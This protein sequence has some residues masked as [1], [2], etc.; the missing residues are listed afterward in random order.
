M[1]EQSNNN[2]KAADIL[3]Q[4]ANSGVPCA[5]VR[6]LIAD[7]SID[8]AYAI[9]QINI[10]RNLAAGGRLVGSKIGLTAK[11]VQK[12]LGVDQPDFGCLLADMAVADGEEIEWSRVIQPKVEAEVALVLEH[13]LS[14]EKHT[15]A[16]LIK[17]TAYVLPALEIVGSR[18]QNWDIRLADTIADNA[19]CGLFV[20]GNRPVKL[21]KVDLINCGMV[22]EQ[23]G[24]PVSVG[25]GAACLGNPLYAALWLADTLS[26][27]GAP[28]RAGDVILTG[29]LG[30]M[31][32]ANAGDVFHA[33]INGLG[34]VSAYFAANEKGDD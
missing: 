11:S 13:D 9:Q 24:E 22:I 31:V 17:A 3:W 1:T 4:A 23:R 28:L 6:D 8:A 15:I 19:S 26:K 14:F 5:P 27:R 16:D 12:Q 30:P 32:S 20:L 34:S 33:H 29:A 21:S 25:T 7:G 18:I 10:Q 2:Q